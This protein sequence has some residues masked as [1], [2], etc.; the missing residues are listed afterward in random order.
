[1][2]TVFELCEAVVWMAYGQVGW[3]QQAESGGFGFA[4]I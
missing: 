3:G 1:M 2:T 4:P